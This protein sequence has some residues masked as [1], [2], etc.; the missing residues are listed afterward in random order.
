MVIIEWGL[1]A[2]YKDEWV[3][4]PA[5]LFA[6][7][8]IGLTVDAA[9]ARAEEVGFHPETYPLPDVGSNVWAFRL[10][11]EGDNVPFMVKL[12]QKPNEPISH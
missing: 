6:F 2:L 12:E 11:V 3:P 9:R 5:G 1:P 4:Y 7:L 10:T 8:A